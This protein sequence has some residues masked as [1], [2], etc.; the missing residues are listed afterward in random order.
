MIKD[1]INIIDIL[2]SVV[3]S[4]ITGMCQAIV[5]LFDGN[6]F[7]I[8]L[9]CIIYFLFIIAIAYYIALFFIFLLTVVMF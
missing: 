8:C 2:G 9:I 5:S 6:E 4:I 3:N 7:L 1:I